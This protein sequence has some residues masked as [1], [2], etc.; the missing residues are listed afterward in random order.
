MN[1]LRRTNTPG[2]GWP[3][4]ELSS[5]RLITLPLLIV[6]LAGALL[7]AYLIDQPLT[8]VFSWRETSTAMVAAS[9]YRQGLNIMYPDVSSNGPAFSYQ[10]GALPT[11]SYLAAL[12]YMLVGEHDWVGRGLAMLAGLW[13]IFALF[14]LVRRVW[15]EPHALAAAAMLALLPG[16]VLIDRSFLPEP[17]ALALST[18]CLWMFAAYYQSERRRYLLLGCLAG[19]LGFLTSF[20]S[21]VVVPALIYAF[22]ALR[23]RG[24]VEAARQP[25]ALTFALIAT[26]APTALWATWTR[27]MVLG[28][29]AA[30]AAG[31]ALWVWQDGLLKW[32]GQGYYLR[33]TLELVLGWLWTAPVLGL[34]LL[35]LLFGPASASLAAEAPP[36]TERRAPWLFHWWLAGCAVLYL[37]GARNLADLPW[38]AHLASPAVAALA[39]HGLVLLWTLGAAPGRWP[40]KLRVG[41]AALAVL[42]AGQLALPRISEP[43]YAL[44]GYQLGMALRQIA[45]PNE[46]VVTLASDGR[47]P[48]AIYYSQRRG[49]LFPPRPLGPAWNGLPETDEQAIQQLEL[50]R[51]QGAKWLGI[52]SDRSDLWVDRPELLEYIKQTCEYTTKLSGGYVI[53]RILSPAELAHRSGS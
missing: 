13:S 7:R 25:L 45:Q 53:Y 18:T 30:S 38:V 42:A 28:T 31:G 37:L 26:I 9:Y 48:I 12:A 52:V 4:F 23:D 24:A 19:A 41:L 34:L 50:L 5:R 22:W 46:L 27:Q 14:Q 51:G 40:A 15:D 17:V 2:F 39:G 16:A 47:D 29:P 20:P 3:A 32:L 36:E 10:P 43:S 21:L 35:G 49:W 6:L 44:Q 1:I 33:G 11:I 8:D